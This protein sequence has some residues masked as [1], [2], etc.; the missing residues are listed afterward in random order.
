MERNN[1]MSRTN[2][3][4]VSNEML[5]HKLDLWL[6][7]TFEKSR[8]DDEVAMSFNHKRV[9]SVY[10]Q[11]ATRVGKHYAV[12]LPF[13]ECDAPVLPNNLGSVAKQFSS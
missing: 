10:K 3:I 5:D 9:L 12:A 13:K 8:H 1:S 2:F 11:S 7:T 4:R 6:D